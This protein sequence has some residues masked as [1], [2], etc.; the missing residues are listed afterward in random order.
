MAVS[1]SR[2]GVLAWTATL[3]SAG[4]LG[5]D[6][7]TATAEPTA[8]ETST[9]TAT[10]SPTETS[11]RT[12][13]TEAAAYLPPEAEGWRLVDAEYYPYSRFGA[14]DGARGYYE[15]DGVELQV[16]V[17]RFDSRNGEGFTSLDQARI[18]YCQAG[19]PVVLTDGRFM[20]AAGTGTPTLTETATPERPPTMA[21]T[22]TA[23][24]VET[25]IALLRHSP[26]LAEEG[27]R[28][29]RFTEADC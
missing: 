17:M 24:A 3:L 16:L 22:P 6:E 23:D 14:N 29:R 27:I 7:P 13:E 18:Q 11:A 25:T 19:W 4:C 15:R 28:E 20:V 21:A 1:W 9:E 2:R 26:E 10:A 12:P 5:G 8:S